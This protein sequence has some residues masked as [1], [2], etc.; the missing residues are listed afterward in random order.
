MKKYKVTCLKCKKHDVLLID[1]SQVLDYEAKFQTPFLSFRMRPDQQWGFECRCGNDS[2]LLKEEMKDFDKLVQGD[3][4]G[5]AKILKNIKESPN[6][7][8]MET[9]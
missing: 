5:I 4:M 6:K 1:G 8:V 7:F 3:E 2:R 9:I